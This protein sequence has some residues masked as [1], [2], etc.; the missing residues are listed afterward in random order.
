MVKI[1]TNTSNF[2]LRV[3]PEIITELKPNEVFVF[4]SNESGFHS[5]GAALFARNNFGAVYGVGHGYTGQCYA[6]PTKDKK[7]RT[8]RLSIIAIYVLN[9]IKKAEQNPDKIH[10]VTKIG[11]GL[12]SLTAEQIAPMFLEAIDVKNIYLPQEFWIIIYNIIGGKVYE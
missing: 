6:L 9:F 12:A 5:L 7:V 2:I 3:T 1:E 11:C 10:L 4:G 8:M